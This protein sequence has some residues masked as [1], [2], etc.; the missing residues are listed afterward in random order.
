MRN[1]KRLNAFIPKTNKSLWTW[2]LIIGS[3][4]IAAVQTASNRLDIAQF[5]QRDQAEWQQ[6]EFAGRTNYSW[7]ELNGAAVLKAQCE[8]GASALY[9]KIEV[10]LSQTP[11]LNWHWLVTDIPATKTGEK[12]KAGDDYPAR[13]YVVYDGGVLKWQTRAINYVW[14]KNQPPG[15]AWPS[16]FTDKAMMVSLQRGPA[17]ELISESINVRTDFKRYFGY[18]LDKI[19][20]VA[21]MTDCD[22]TK[23]AA[24]GYYGDIWFSAE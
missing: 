22:N 2:L 1:L 24:S 6:R 11:V 18:E 20:G 7:A 9:R 23:R 21:V 4:S 19:H 16:P 13:V 17:D 3:L 15:E 5:S 12:T 14:S 8:D 10:D